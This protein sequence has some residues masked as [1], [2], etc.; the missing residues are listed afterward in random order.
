[1]AIGNK[2]LLSVGASVKV[3]HY[4]HFETLKTNCDLQVFSYNILK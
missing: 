3:K 4:I 1:M 2:L